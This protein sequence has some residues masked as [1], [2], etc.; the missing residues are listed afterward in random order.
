MF[1]CINFSSCS[2]SS[3]GEKPTEADIEKALRRQYE[4]E[5][6]GTSPKKT[7]TIHSIKIGSSETAN[8]QDEIDGIPSKGLVTAAEIDFTI[9]SHYTDQII[10]AKKVMIAK[11][12]KN[13]MNEWSVMN[14]GSKNEE[15]IREPVQ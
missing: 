6:T 14:D 15:T 2:S 8:L 7:V 11:V 13:K 9:R 10:G 12:Y 3:S 4:T 1:A 5:K